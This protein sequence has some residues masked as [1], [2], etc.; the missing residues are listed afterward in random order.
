VGTCGRYCDECSSPYK[1]LKCKWPFTLVNG[2]CVCQAPNGLPS[3]LSG[4]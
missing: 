2:A 1:C 4:C 3:R